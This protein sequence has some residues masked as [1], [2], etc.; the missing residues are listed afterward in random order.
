[1]PTSAAAYLSSGLPGKVGQIRRVRTIAL[2]HIGGHSFFAHGF[3]KSDK[4][5]VSTKELNA[6]KQLAG[7]LRGFSDEQIEAAQ[8]AGEM[9]EVKNDGGEKE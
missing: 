5:N 1:M 6:L 9:I 2:F 3:A 4:A 8:V 7:V